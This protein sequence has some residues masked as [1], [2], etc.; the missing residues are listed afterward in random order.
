LKE[1]IAHFQALL[2]LNPRDNQNN[3]DALICCL[4]EAGDDEALGKQLPRLRF[5]DGDTIEPQDVAGT[6]WHYTHACW[7]FRKSTEDRK[8]ARSALKTAFKHN[9]YVP[10]FLLGTFDLPDFDELDA[11]SYGDSTEAALY[12]NLALKGWE[13]TPGALAWLEEEAKR[14]RLFPMK[15][16]EI[17][18]IHT[19][20]SQ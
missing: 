5:Y 19:V 7:L 12:A 16:Q 20:P 6:V 10:S 17:P 1:A 15:E 2:E 4:L 8:K 9:R 14:A 18:A 3:G 11:Y 13:N